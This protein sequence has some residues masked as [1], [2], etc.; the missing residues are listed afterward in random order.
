MYSL[1]SSGLLDGMIRYYPP[2]NFP[3]IWARIDEMI[4]ASELKACEMVQVEMQ[5]RDDEVLAWMQARPA[6]ILHLDEGRQRIVR[7]LLRDYPR[8]VDERRGRSGADPF[9]IAVAVQNRCPVITGEKPSGNL[10]KPR[11][12]D[13]CRALGIET[14]TFLDLI[15]QKG[16]VFR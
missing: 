6:L 10:E 7:D 8:L 12:P 16:W 3:G 4:A 1:D 9:V 2:E 11:I 15:R 14:M 5:R 13:V